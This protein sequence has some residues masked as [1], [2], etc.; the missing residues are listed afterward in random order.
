[1]RIFTGDGPPPVNVTGNRA[2]TDHPE[3]NQLGEV[4]VAGDESPEPAAALEAL[5]Q[6]GL[7]RVLCEG[8]PYLLSSLID[9]DLVDDMCLT[10]T[11]FLAGS[12]PTTMQP[13]S[14]RIEPTRLG[15]RHVLQYDGLLYLR[16]S[17][18]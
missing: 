3:L 18:A 2:L 1:L 12:Q 4:V 15:L 8:G 16:Y 10:V 5:A 11:P 13:A 17:R 6:L 14:D 9:A 7:T